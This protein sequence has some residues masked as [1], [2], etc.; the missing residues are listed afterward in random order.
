[1]KLDFF[2]A[3]VAGWSWALKY[4]KGMDP[5]QYSSIKYIQRR[6]HVRM[7]FISS[8]NKHQQQVHHSVMFIINFK[9]KEND[10][11]TINK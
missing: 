7:F 2:V 9:D 4:I 11:R 8:E 3:D 5:S 6:L 10:R 1:M